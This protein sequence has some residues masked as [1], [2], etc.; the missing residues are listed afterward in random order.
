MRKVV[1]FLRLCISFF[2]GDDLGSSENKLSIREANKMFVVHSSMWNVELEGG[3]VVV[4][5]V[6]G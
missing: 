5:R 3:G 1:G 4:V 2:S 6:G